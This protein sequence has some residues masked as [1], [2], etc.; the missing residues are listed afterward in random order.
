MDILAGIIPVTFELAAGELAFPAYVN[1]PGRHHGFAQGLP[2]IQQID[3][4]AVTETPLWIRETVH[5]RLFIEARM[6]R[7]EYTLLEREAIVPKRKLRRKTHR[8]RSVSLRSELH[9]LPVKV[10]DIQGMLQ[11]ATGIQ[12]KPQNSAMHRQ[13]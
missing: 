5:F 2:E 8:Q 13:Q 6:P 1:P 3:P 12:S 7:A 9:S 10:P 4:A 11:R